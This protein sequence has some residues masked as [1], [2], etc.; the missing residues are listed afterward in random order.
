MQQYIQQVEALYNQLLSSALTTQLIFVGIILAL[1]FSWLITL[2]LQQWNHKAIMFLISQGIGV[3]VAMQTGGL[4]IVYPSLMFFPPLVLGSLMWFLKKLFST[5]KENETTVAIPTNKGTKYISLKEHVGVFGS[6]GAGKTESGFVPIIKHNFK[7]GL[8]Q[9]IFDYKEWELMEKVYGLA[10]TV[11]QE[12]LKRKER[13]EK[14]Y[15]I[16]TINTICLDDPNLSDHFNPVAPR[17]L[18]SMKDV[19]TFATD[20]FD[21]LYPGD[22]GTNFFKDSGSAAFAGT[23]WYYKE[24][25]PELCTWGMICATV[26]LASS[27]QLM[28]LINTSTRAKVL[29]APFMDGKGNERQLASVK[30]SMTAALKKVC[31]P[32]IFMIMSKDELDLDINDPKDPRV[33]GIVNNPTYDP[34]YLPVIALLCRMVMNRIS[35]RKRRPCVIIFDEGSAL[36]FRMLDRVLATLR[37]F[38]VLVVWGLQDKVQGAI[39]YSENVLKAI[40]TNLTVLFLG[41]AN[42]PDTADFYARLFAPRIVKRRSVSRSADGRKTTTISEEE[43]AKYKSVE[44][45]Q[46]DPGQFYI[47][48][49]KANDMNVRIKQTKY[50]DIAPVK[51][52]NYTEQEIQDNF[53]KIFEDAQKFLDENTV[54]E[55]EGPPISR[56]ELSM[57]TT[58]TESDQTRVD[59]P[60]DPFGLKDDIA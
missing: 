22:D 19:E 39:M 23:T 8:A 2:N 37:T 25:H 48:D 3:T 53:D 52:H 28:Q 33:L 26:I 47:I 43:K 50:E 46:R 59:D 31:T 4:P 7:W 55:K 32:E 5:Q 12:N 57:Q 16:P 11:E 35:K 51:K 14:T 34:V 24:T 9:L 10:K 20:F 45:R 41:K 29:A 49:S 15:L 27:N 60:D 44:F 40:L 13:G 18:G 42:D 1:S 58:E 21:N 30:S 6:T 17:F 56:G 38:K 54:V 36:K